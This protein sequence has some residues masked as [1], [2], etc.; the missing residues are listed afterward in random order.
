MLV[1]QATSAQN[2]KTNF[3]FY[4]CLYQEHSNDFH[5][6]VTL[7]LLQHFSSIGGINASAEI[8]RQIY[9]CAAKIFMLHVSS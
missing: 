7:I 8:E 1:W 5:I 4:S 9:I 6:G 2:F 3:I